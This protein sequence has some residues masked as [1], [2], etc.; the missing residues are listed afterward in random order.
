MTKK[1]NTGVSI[2][3]VL[4]ALAIFMVLMV[5]IVQGIRAA[6]RTSTQSK[7]TQYRNEFAEN[8]MED[9]KATPINALAGNG[10]VKSGTKYT[11]SGT[12]QLGT[13]KTDYAWQI[14][15]D[16]SH[17][18]T[19]AFNVN[20]LSYGIIEDMD[21]RKVA[22]LDGTI[23]NYDVTAAQI[24]K[25]KKLQRLKETDP[26]GYEQQ[27]QGT[28]V[29]IFAGDSGYRLITIEVSGA[30]ATGYT[31]RCIMGY[32][33]SNA[34]LGNDNYVEYTAMAQVF[35]ELPNIYLTYNPCYYVDGYCMDDYIAIDTNGLD[36]SE[37]LE[38]NL[39]LVEVAER[40]SQNIIDANIS[41]IDNTNTLYANDILNGINRDDVNIH[42][43][44]FMKGSNTS[45]L[46][47][48]NVYHN[49]GMN[50]YT[51]T[52]GNTQNK[53][54]KKSDISKFWYN[55][56]QNVVDGEFDLFVDRYNS[57]HPS[58]RISAIPLQDS[59]GNG[60]TVD[61]VNA[62]VQGDRGLYKVKV[63]LQEGTIVDTSK[64]PVL[65]G[66]KGGSEK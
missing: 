58:D 57:E 25:S 14:E 19:A 13:E 52:D 42:L 34:M 48:I 39:F 51:D 11:A 66:T 65:E 45:F 18:D 26:V 62:A 61:D 63:W 16:S 4:I 64:D 6:L 15:L 49:I 33:D 35:D 28:G 21:Y 20:N 54:N 12:T 60:A 27:M 31:V 46:N 2:V 32:R 40:Y 47:K 23:Y 43:A 38:V 56:S 5:P 3:E 36:A 50:T 7:E 1:K 22:L 17:Y 9:V 8:L 37:D 41:D 44:A 53:I 59:A 10:Y 24:L 29:N 55:E 30:K